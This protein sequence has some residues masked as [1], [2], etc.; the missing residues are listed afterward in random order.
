VICGGQNGLVWVDPATGRSGVLLDTIAGQPLK[1][2]NDM[3]P[4]SRGGLYFGALDN[5]GDYQGTAGLTALCHVDA[6]GHARVLQDGLKFPNGVGLSPDGRRLY[7]TESLRGIFVYDVAGDGGVSHRRVF[8]PREDGD[9]LAVDAEGFVWSASFSG[10][11]IVRHRP[12]GEIAERIPVPHKVVTSL[13]FG[14]AD[15][16]DVYVTT[17]GNSGVDALLGGD[18]PPREAALFHGRSNVPGLPTPRTRFRIP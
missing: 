13:C 2:V 17:G 8:S 15:S 14:G 5:E 18:M 7:H 1:G 11:D 16:R 4:D 10:G 9:G 3:F 6:D 12:D